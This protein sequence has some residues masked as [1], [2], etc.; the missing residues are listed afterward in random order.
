MNT[1][2]SGR[3]RPP[4]RRFIVRVI[5]AVGLNVLCAMWGLKT[6][7]SGMLVSQSWP[8]P[9]VM[10]LTLAY[11]WGDRPGAAASSADGS[12]SGNTDRA[13]GQ[14]AG[15]T[16]ALS[17]VPLIAATA[18][19]GSFLLGGLLVGRPLPGLLWMG[20]AAVGQALLIAVIYRRARRE[21][22][23]EPRT[24]REV[25]WLS[26]AI[27]VTSAVVVALGALPGT[28]PFAVE[29]TQ[30]LRWLVRLGSYT[31]AIVL[32][33]L[34]LLGRRRARV[35]PKPHRWHLAFFLV[36]AG[37]CIF[38]PSAYP[39]VTLAWMPLIPAVWG[40]LILA[41]R[42]AVQLCL[43]M[44]VWTFAARYLPIEGF[45]VSGAW[46]PRSL[47]LDVTLT[48][49][50][51]A[52]LMIVLARDERARLLLELDRERRL[53]RSNE[54]VL[55]TVFQEMSDG[56][57]V[58]EPEGRI[59]FANR[60]A[61]VILGRP[62]PE[63]RPESY[64][65][66]FD[67]LTEDGRPIVEEA[68]LG[69]EG[70]GATHA[71]LTVLLPVQDGEDPRRIHFTVS[72]VTTSAGGRMVSVFRDVTSEH[73][74]QQEMATFARNIAHDLKGP[75]A[76][77]VGWSEAAATAMKAG[78]TELAVQGADQVRRA[79]LRMSEM[80]DA[81]LGYTVA[82][83]GTLRLEDLDLEELVIGVVELFESS[84][85]LA[86]VFWLDVSHTVRG[87]R[88]LITQLINNLV[89]NAVKYA[90]DGE[91][92]R[93]NITTRDLEEPGWVELDVSDEGIGIAEGERER[94]FSPFQRGDSMSDEV[95][96]VGLGLALCR[97]A[98]RRHG[99]SISASR[100]AAGGTTIRV[101]LPAPVS[102]RSR[103]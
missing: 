24:A 61:R 37:V 55:R 90:R 63:Q 83:E 65:R 38:L 9:G 68:E 100:N 99:G 71:S 23:W 43:V 102:E 73:A 14:G 31:W 6:Y 67:L 42:Q 87:D 92:A 54:D 66:Y 2:A 82:R 30:A 25:V 98:A 27:A 15:L 78:D 96:G 8:V 10:F 22:S 20:F 62:L 3:L 49:G 81:W 64:A 57:V 91:P 95:S 70:M 33:G 26:A 7:R 17:R 51:A 84:G 19:L 4:D 89:A 52:C 39:T 58:T 79:N 41:P 60:A 69:P 53:A 75:L 32:I 21:D 72:P 13:G 103:A 94:L 74:R 12:T 1:I 86:P 16:E 46:L 97:A 35:V 56:V 11:F 50:A 48:A 76:T 45:D 34:L 88:A 85:G 36:V 80:I 5:V 18:L 29:E 28:E 59:E 93:I 40:G 101:S 47:A 44:S 77:A